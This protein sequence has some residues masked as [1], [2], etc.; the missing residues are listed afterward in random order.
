MAGTP[1]GEARPRAPGPAAQGTIHPAARNS[2]YHSARVSGTS[3][4][5]PASVTRCGVVVPSTTCICAGWRVIHAVAIPSGVTSYFAASR[6]M[7]A[8]SYAY[9]G[10]PRNTPSKNLAWNG[11]QAWT[12]MSCRRQKSRTPPPSRT[13]A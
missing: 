9:S 6:S 13:I 1:G 10:C 12:V 8:L 3:E 4:P 5:A 2:S 11:D 7:T